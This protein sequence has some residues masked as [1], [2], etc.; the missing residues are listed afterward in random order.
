MTAPTIDRLC[1]CGHPAKWHF[2][3]G[4]N[5]LDGKPSPTHCNQWDCKCRKFEVRS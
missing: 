5:L 2:F 4:E 3:N 1:F